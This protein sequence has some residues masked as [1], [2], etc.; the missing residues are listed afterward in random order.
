MNKDQNDYFNE[1]FGSISS[2]KDVRIVFSLV[3]YLASIEHTNISIDCIISAILFYYKDE[4]PED[5]VTKLYPAAL[6]YQEFRKTLDNSDVSI[7]FANF[8]NEKPLFQP[9]RIA[10]RVKGKRGLLVKRRLYHSAR[11]R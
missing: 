7:S 10:P 8:A 3:E 2:S 4:H 6:Y 5:F 11:N 9:V 1:I